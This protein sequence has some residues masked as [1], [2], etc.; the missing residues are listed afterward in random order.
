MTI[1]APVRDA[2]R[3]LG[4]PVEVRRFPEGTKTAEDAARDILRLDRLSATADAVTAAV[5]DVSPSESPQTLASRLDH[6]GPDLGVFVMYSRGVALRRSKASSMHSGM[7]A[8]PC[9]AKA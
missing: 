9:C 4:H 6:L 5:Q 8:P 1:P 2:A 7:D 3:V